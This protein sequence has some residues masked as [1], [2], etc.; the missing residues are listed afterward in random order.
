[1]KPKLCIQ[2]HFDLI[3]PWCFIGKRHLDTALERF[4][5]ARPD[6]DVEVLWVSHELLPDTP[7]EGLPYQPFYEQRLGG[8]AAV[9]A[10]R[11]Q[12]QEAARC[13]GIR[14]AFHRIERM[15]NTR[16]AH[17]LLPDL[18]RPGN[19]MATAALI[20]KLFQGYFEEG[21]DIGDPKVLQRL[22]ASEPAGDGD[23]AGRHQ[24]AQAGRME[25]P[26][27]PLFVFNEHV[28]LSGAQSPETL[29]DRMHRATRALP[30]AATAT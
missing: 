10:R 21:Q 7:P 18:A 12:V 27:V 8:A 9:A 23:D 3:C 20:E 14:F 6:V 5:H 24:T 26:G 4:S 1:M 13:S 11:A 28:A 30:L 19:A 22:A 16:L 25:V 29:L 2:V 17:R 15:P